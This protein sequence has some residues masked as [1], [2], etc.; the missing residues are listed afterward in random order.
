MLAGCL[1]RLYYYCTVFS[2]VCV[3]SVA[4]HWI[5]SLPP[6][7]ESGNLNVHLSFTKEHDSPTARAPMWCAF[8]ASA[9]DED[10]LPDETES[11]ILKLETTDRRDTNSRVL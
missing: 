9:I 2:T 5:M 11:S 1:R 7:P 4:F 8:N 6:D 10:T 3:L